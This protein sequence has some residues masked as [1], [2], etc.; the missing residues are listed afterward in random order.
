M[1]MTKKEII[2]IGKQVLELEAKAVQALVPRLDENFADAVQT[3][4]R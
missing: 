2:H 3:L 1:A 4:S